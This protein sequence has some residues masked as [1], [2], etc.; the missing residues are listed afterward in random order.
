MD[1]KRTAAVSAVLLGTVASGLLYLRSNPNRGGDDAAP[2]LGIG[3][4]MNEAEL[5][6]TGIDGKVLYRANARAA[7][8]SL[9]NGAVELEQ[10]DMIYGPL[11]TVP[12]DLRASTGRIPPDDNIIELRG[13]VIAVSRE[14]AAPVTTVRTDYL[15]ID[16]E[17]GVAETER[18]VTV[19][20][21][22]NKVFATG[23]RVYIREDRL[24]L[25]SNVNGKFIP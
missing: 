13:D 25:V 8:Q 4:Y 5:V 19:E 7:S 16:P 24:Q 15:E 10:I 22:G 6:G 20:R 9:E 17:T 1:L 21:A 2:R 12:W 23:L 14:G 11:S 18:K 3:Y